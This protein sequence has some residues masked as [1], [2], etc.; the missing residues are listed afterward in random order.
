MNDFFKGY[1]IINNLPYGFDFQNQD[2]WQLRAHSKWFFE[3]KDHRL[4]ELQ[5]VYHAFCGEYLDFSPESLKGL[6]NFF[7]KAIDTEK[8]SEEEYAAKRAKV[9]DDIPIDD[10]DLTIRSRSLIVDVGIYMG[11]VMIRNHKN[12]CWE[13]YKPRS[14]RNVER[15]Y[16]VIRINDNIHRNWINPIWL[17]DVQ[18]WKVSRNRFEPDGIYKVYNYHCNEISPEFL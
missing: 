3:N 17:I 14:R 12:M 6:S 10:Y 1:N 18:G 4:S 11:E 7:S 13:Q 15:G 2:G 5:N 16:M 9:P 8:L